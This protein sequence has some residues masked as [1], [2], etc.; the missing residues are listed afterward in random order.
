MTGLCNKMDVDCAWLVLRTAPTRSGSARADAG[1]P[2]GAR[3]PVCSIGGFRRLSLPSTRGRG[4]NLLWVHAVCTAS[5]TQATACRLP[6]CR[7]FPAARRNARLSTARV[8]RPWL[9]RSGASECADW[10]RSCCGG[11][12]MK[13][14]W[15]TEYHRRDVTMGLQACSSMAERCYHMAEVGGSIPSAPTTRR[16]SRMGGRRDWISAGRRMPRLGCS[17][18]LIRRAGLDSP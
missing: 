16:P 14:M 15:R 9:V 2:K 6:T 4:R 11:R 12:S 17:E 8:A 3:Q 1:S 18:K 13:A 7:A 5:L 10:T